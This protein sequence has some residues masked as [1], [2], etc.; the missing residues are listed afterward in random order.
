M[1]LPFNFKKIVAPTPQENQML[2]RSFGTAR[3]RLR[4]DTVLRRECCD[5][6]SGR[7]GMEVDQLGLRGRPMRMGRSGMPRPVMGVIGIRPMLIS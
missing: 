6:L 1:I 3:H 4:V 2:R 5:R 7:S